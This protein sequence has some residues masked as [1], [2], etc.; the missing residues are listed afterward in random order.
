ML[1]QDVDEALR[2]LNVLVVSHRTDLSGPTEALVDFLGRRVNA[3]GFISHPFHYCVDHRSRGLLLDD[4]EVQLDQRLGSWPHR[5]PFIFA[6][7][8]SLT[9][10]FLRRFGRRFHLYIGVN[11]FNMLT[12]LWL[13]RLGLVD[14]T[15]LY[16]IDWMPRR[17]PQPWLNWLYHR[18]DRLAVSGCDV[19]W[20]LSEPIR[21]VRAGQGKPSER[22]LYTP[23]G[24]DLASIRQPAQEYAIEEGRKRLVLL[25]ALAPS[26][27]V[28]TVLQAFP[29]VRAQ[30][31]DAELIVIGRTPPGAQEDGVPFPPYEERLQQLGAGVKLMGVLPHDEVLR[32]LPSYGISLAPY[33]V[34]ATNLSNWANPSRVIDSLA[35]GLPVLVT[36]VPAI[37]QEI[38]AN[39]AG[40]VV[41]DDPDSLANAA[42]RLLDD[43]DLYWR[44]RQNALALASHYDWA[45]IFQRA[46][47]ATLCAGDVRV[48]LVASP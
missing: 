6:K 33:T 44:M 7:D 41:E 16:S 30:H 26:K 23:V 43:P 18:V 1:P 22:N 29:K 3:L 28:D 10:H 17:F 45:A 5:E 8:L 14:K 11:P 40:L 37:A 19:A 13:Q 25:G 4:G 47:A 2:R 24:V 20:N 38:G 21:E 27:G 12:G 36:R 42:C 9:L 39:D 34:S 48:Q 32:R 46:F 31:P 35:A 15:V